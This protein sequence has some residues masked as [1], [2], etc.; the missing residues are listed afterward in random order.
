[1]NIR[2]H[3]KKMVLAAAAF[4]WAGCNDDVG[5]NVQV[6]ELPDCGDGSEASN[7]ESGCIGNGGGM[8]ALYGVAPVIDGSSSSVVSSDSCEQNCDEMISSSSQVADSSATAPASSAGSQVDSTLYK[9]KRD[10][11]GC[12]DH[13]G[14]E[15]YSTYVKSTWSV[16]EKEC[17]D[18]AKDSADAYLRNKM[19]SGYYSK[20]T[21]ECLESAF[22]DIRNEEEECLYGV[23]YP[24][25]GNNSAQSITAVKSVRCEDDTY[26]DH[27]DFL[28]AVESYHARKKA[29]AADYVRYLGSAE[30]CFEGNKGNSSTEEN[31]PMDSLKTALEN[32]GVCDG[33]ISSVQAYRAPMTSPEYSGKVEAQVKALNQVNE[34]L[35]SSDAKNFTNL[36]RQC[37]ENMKQE[38]SN[39]FAALYGSPGLEETDKWVA[40]CK[41]EGGSIKTE[42]SP[43]YEAQIKNDAERSE[44]A[45]AEEAEKLKNKIDNCNDTSMET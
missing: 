13:G 2:K 45:E 18:L 21:L 16:S 10:F 20:K 33:N 22:E 14:V 7:G 25:I 19:E 4:F 37:L 36:Q 35:G 12:D 17:V 39:G 38:L 41:T 44:K 28:K 1:M 9:L 3:W 40:T 43:A 5:T 34:L 26:V 15:D 42:M 31:E 11:R 6:K 30:A 23:F 32:Q 8:I 27:P 24:V 29:C